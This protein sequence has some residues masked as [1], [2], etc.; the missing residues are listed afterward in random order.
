ME[1]NKI[2]NLKKQVNFARPIFI[3]LLVLVVVVV[4]S[5]LKLTATV[6]I[7][8]VI[9]ILLSLVLEPILIVLN[10]KFKI[11][12]F[13]GI[14][15]VLVFLI[16]GFVAFAGLFVSSLNSIIAEYP[17]YEARFTTIYK[18]IGV[19]FGLTFDENFTL[20]ENLLGQANIRQTLQSFA[21]SFSGNLLNFVKEAVVVLLFVIFFLLDL[22][23]LRLKL[24][25]MFGDK[26]K[27]KVTFIVTNVIEQTIRYLSV[28]FFVSLAT[29]ILVFI[30]TWLIGLDF[31]II[32]GFIAFLLNFIPNFGSII[33]GILT[34]AFALIQFF[35]SP[36]PVILT[37]LLMV[38]VNFALGNFLEP[39][40]QGR[41][42]GLS[43]FVIIVSLSFWGWL[44]GFTG[45][46]V[47]VPMMVILKII[48]ENFSIL[49]PLAV[50]LGNYTG[51]EEDEIKHKKIFTRK[52]KTK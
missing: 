35:P 29:G 11:P 15:L 2:S 17:K 7:P 47:G 43:P 19:F 21:L 3:L 42:L 37:G 24:Q 1:D 28:K 16:A 5:V 48:C 14:I 44:W 40:I 52:N 38:G 26:N 4:T 36:T 30:G 49:E 18:E 41:E 34:T 10:K 27:E 25:K 8:V 50:M 13:L 6:I 23:Y 32:W 45:L 33:S 9:A 31:P 20:I 12:W 46:V 22:R 51:E 39:K